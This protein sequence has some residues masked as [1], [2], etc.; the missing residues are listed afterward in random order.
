MRCPYHFFCGQVLGLRDEEDSAEETPMLI[1]RVLHERLEEFLA[2]AA[3]GDEAADEAGLAARWGGV[4][5]A[6]ATNRPVLALHRRYWRARAAAVAKWQAGRQAAGWRMR[7][8]EYPLRSEWRGRAQTV[9]LRGKIDRLDCDADG[10]WSV[11]DYKSGGLRTKKFIE[12]G[13]DLQIFLYAYFY[14]KEFGFSVAEAG[15]VKPVG[16]GARPLVWDLAAVDYRALVEEGFLR[17]LEDID[18]GAPVVA[19]GVE[20]KDCD[21]VGVCRKPFWARAS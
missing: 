2:P 1:G 16:E 12:A 6:F 9:M 14:E 13:G 4:V 11:M 19:N 20:C 7:L 5:D 18:R 17:A 10:A 21:S 3:G 15:L 8:S